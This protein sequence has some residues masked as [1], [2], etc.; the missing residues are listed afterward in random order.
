MGH[1]GGDLSVNNAFLH[2]LLLSRLVGRNSTCILENGDGF[3]I[4][5]HI[6]DKVRCHIRVLAVDRDGEEHRR[7][8]QDSGI[9][10]ILCHRV[11]HGRQLEVA[12]LGD[13]GHQ[14]GGSGENSQILV[15]PVGILIR[16]HSLIEHALCKGRHGPGLHQL[17]LIVKYLRHLIG[18]KARGVVVLH[19]VLAV[20]LF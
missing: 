13:A 11:A 14:G 10:G 5:Q 18:G 19:Q 7:G 6:V 1:H 20:H 3:G 17:S 4:I 8:H 16:I 2:Q 9:H 12:G 15:Q